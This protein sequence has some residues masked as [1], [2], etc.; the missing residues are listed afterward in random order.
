[1]E[2]SKNFVC[3]D[4][5]YSNYIKNVPAPLFRKSF[6]LDEVPESAEILICGLGFY[7]L[8]VNGKKITK[9]YLAPYISNSDHICYYDKYDIAK[10][11]VTGENVIGVMLGDGHQVGKTAS[12]D[13]VYNVTNSAPLLALT[14]EIKCKNTTLTFDAEDFVCKKGPIIFNDLRSGVFYD[15]RLEEDG[16]NMPGFVEDG[17]HKPIS[18]VYK[19]RGYAKLCDAEPIRVSKELKPVSITKGE[20][21]DYAV[22]NQEYMLKYFNGIAPFETAAERTG[23]Y[24]YDFGE[25]NAGTLRLKI[26]GQRGQ[27][28]S[29]QCGEQ[30]VDG[31]MSYKNI[32][33][34]PDGFCQRDIYY[35]KGG[36]EETF[37]VMFTYHGLRYVYVSGITEEQ[38]TEDLL[39]YLVMS[40]DLEKRGGFE[41]SDDMANKIYEISQRSDISNFYYFPTDCPHREKNGWT[42]DA[43]TSAEHMIM[44]IGVENSWREWLNNIR[45]AQKEDGRL[46][47]IIPTDTWGYKW[48]NGPAWDRVI[49]EL[50]YNAYKYRGETEIIKENADSMLRYLEYTARMRNEKGLADYGLG[51]W[52]PVVRNDGKER[53]DAP[54]DFVNAAMIM[55]MCR[56]AVEMFEAVNLPLHKS[57]AQSL[58]EQMREAVRREYID[59]EACTVK[60]RCQSTQAMAIYYDIFNE[61]EKSKA[62]EILKDIVKED[63]NNI[64]SGYLGL[65]VI[66]HVLAQYGEVD[67][68]Y[69]MITKKEFP[70]YGYWVERGETTLL[71]IFA[72]YDE[73]FCSSKNHHFLGDVINWFMRYPG[74][75]NVV[76]HNEVKIKPYFVEKLDSCRSFHILP[77]GR[78]EVEWQRNGDEIMLNITAPNGVKCDADIPAGYDIKKISDGKFICTKGEK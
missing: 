32:N 24:I 77:A 36:E 21:S 23:G 69:N 9:G 27:K 44:T 41:C 4:I 34:Y 58:G 68:A 12:W 30:L 6:I 63:N 51:D 50:P 70:S 65:R 73:Y 29:L 20:L 2:F 45:A 59:A 74:G 66:F 53:S 18:G 67:L 40:S 1:M 60:Y 10:Y 49:F 17:W 11:L 25:N 5:A 35:L 16:W 3:E 42:G 15:A 14:A 54:L 71:E 28:V 46:P 75:I 47:G 57:F 8:F 37:E 61:D 62:F 13:F 19:P 38:A 72:E 33:F 22:S 64:T 56:Q 43:S 7:D 31:K 48:G 52:V 76:N 55:E 78:V 26:K 39:T